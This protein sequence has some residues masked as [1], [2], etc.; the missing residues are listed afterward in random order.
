[1]IVQDVSYFEIRLHVT[2][3]NLL[4]RHDRNTPLFARIEGIPGR[5]FALSFHSVA[6]EPDPLT[7]TYEVV[8]RM[9]APAD[10]NLFSGMTV[11]VGA[12]NPPASDQANAHWLIPAVAVLSDSDNGE[13]YVWRY[14]PTTQLTEK[15]PVK[16]GQI[17]GNNIEVI[18]G[19]SAGEQ[20]IIAGVHAVQAGMPVHP[21]VTQ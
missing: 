20:I 14:N 16:T 1:V 21:L 15:V 17:Q 19:L 4:E 6:K 18:S 9:P 2:E 12:G 7:G 5:E 8:L 13:H 3:R 11:T 10:L